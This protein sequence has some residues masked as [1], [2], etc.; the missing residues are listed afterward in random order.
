MHTQATAHI[1]HHKAAMDLTVGSPIKRL[2]L[3]MIP[4]VIGN[5]VQQLY[6]VVDTAVVGQTLGGAALSGVGSTGSLSFMILGFVSGLATG[7]SVLI[8]QRRGAGDE[9]GMKKA[10]ATSVVLLL[11]LISALTAVALFT[12]RPLLTVMN[13][14]PEFMQFAVDYI[15]VIFAGMLFSGFS[16]LFMCTLRAIGDSRVPLYF[17]ALACVLNAGMDCL[18]IMACNMGVKGAALATVLANVITAAATFVYM[19]VRYPELRFGVRHFK[20]DLRAYGTHLKLGVPMA[21]Q[22]SIISIG[23][24]FGQSALNTMEDIAVTAY[25][26]ATRIDSISTAVLASFGGAVSMFVGQ[27]FGAKKFDRIKQSSKQFSVFAIALSLALAAIVLGLNRPLVMLFI[28]AA[29]RTEKLFDYAFKYLLLNAGFYFL[30]AVLQMSRS[31]LQGM[32]RGVLPLIS[33]AAEVVSRVVISFIAIRYNSFVIVCLLNSLSWAGADLCLVPSFIIVLAKYVPM[34]GRAPKNKFAAECCAAAEIPDNT[35]TDIAAADL[36][37]T[38]DT[39]TDTAAELPDSDLPDTP[40][41]LPDTGTATTDTTDTADR[42]KSN[43]ADT[44]L[45]ETHMQ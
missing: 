23:M 5:F 30:L 37:D 12:A 4:M 15:T 38:A 43:S 8:S 7:F 18:F 17:V 39:L 40:A 31:S 16:N 3:F 32:G 41:D 35:L 29:E 2:V 14:K 44:T 36:P 11:V 9:E 45:Q 20:P 28:P 19:W 34:F 13:T 10:L 22:M 21:F 33:A 27:N 24:L 25:V 6:S 26:A 1:A 42:E